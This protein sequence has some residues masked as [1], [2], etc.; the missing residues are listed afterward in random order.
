M[1][2]K[3]YRLDGPGSASRWCHN[4][5]SSPRRPERVWGS[6]SLQLSGYESFSLG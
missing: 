4:N 6:C 5:Y 2:T 3:C 1:P